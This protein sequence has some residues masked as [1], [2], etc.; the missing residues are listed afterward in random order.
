MQHVH[1]RIFLLIGLLVFAILWT[2]LLGFGVNANS[3][4]GT[5]VGVMAAEQFGAGAH[6]MYVDESAFPTI[7]VYLA[8]NDANGHPILTLPQEQFVLREDG[9]PVEI[10]DFTTAGG[11]S[12]STILVIDRSG[13]MAEEEKMQSAIEAA[14][15]FI[16]LLQ[17]DTDRLGVIVFDN[18]LTQLAPL[19]WITPAQQANL[20]DLLDSLWPDGGTEFYQAVREAVR[21][22]AAING[23]KV[24]L[25][26]TDGIDNSGQAWLSTAIA[27]AQA[28]NVP[29]YTVGLG[30]GAVDS[31]GL[32][33]LAQDTGGK[34]Y[35]SPTTSELEDIY[36]QIAS[37]LRNEYAVT[38]R[39]LIPNLDGTSR[40]LSVEIVAQGDE[41]QTQGGY[42]VG[43]ILAST[44]DFGIFLPTLLL[45]GSTL[46]GLY[47]AP[48]LLRRRSQRHQER[49]EDENR[50]YSEFDA[51]DRVTGNTSM[52]S[53][54]FMATAAFLVL[55]YS[56]SAPVTTL[57]NSRDAQIALLEPSVA[58]QHA[59]I[60]LT[61]GRYV[62]QD[63]ACQ[64]T[65]QVSYN[66]EA[67][68]LRPTQQNALRD[69]SLIYLGDVALIFHQQGERAWL[70]RTVSLPAEGL[71]CGN[72][73]SSKLWLSG[74]GSHEALIRQEQQ[75]WLVEARM[76][77]CQVSYN[78]DPVHLRTIDGI[79]ALKSGSYLR[80]GSTLLRLE[81]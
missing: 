60:Q 1:Q 5:G 41:L 17:T 28:A 54:S 66:G 46:F 13:S 68:R 24:V 16:S 57:G 77:V 80:M 64:G 75:R 42:A 40:A 35:L 3:R 48:N 62:I 26:L 19:D 39:S 67:D 15:T 10:L 52:V 71:V 23:R 81:V 45:L 18:S 4:S 49:A 76:G 7:T 79:N 29:V 63:L 58:V 8:V 43:G 30:Q 69:G 44:L 25:A 72:T 12:T 53:S 20:Y 22:L 32:A 56:L 27:E 47:Q 11:S 78:G 38:Y 65:T 55:E 61:A 51:A 36:R 33:A 70:E 6:V 34:E 31:A 37:N 14:K 9:S 59:Q 2:F 73:A 21:L 50:P 74:N